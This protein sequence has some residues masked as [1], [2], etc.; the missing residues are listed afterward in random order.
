MFGI[1][2][3]MSMM[4]AIPNSK[5]GS[6]KIKKYGRNALLRAKGANRLTTTHTQNHM[7]FKPK[8]G[9]AKY[10]AGKARNN[11]ATMLLVTNNGYKTILR[12]K[13][14][15]S[16]INVS[17]FVSIIKYFVLLTTML[18]FAYVRCSATDNLLQ[19]LSPLNFRED[20]HLLDGDFIQFLESLRLWNTIVDHDGV[21]VL[22]VRYAD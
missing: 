9:K 17:L 12:I 5:N 20:A 18:H 19:I 15:D 8:N 3:G 13:N 21:D 7:T 6:A 11:A 10:S 14:D 1:Y 2:V 4:D 16:K 22:H